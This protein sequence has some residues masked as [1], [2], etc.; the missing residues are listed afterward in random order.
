MIFE[1]PPRKEKKNKALPTAR[2]GEKKITQ[3]LH[4]EKFL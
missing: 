2:G 4:F 3:A 1:N